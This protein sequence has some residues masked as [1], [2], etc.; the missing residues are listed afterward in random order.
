ML[1]SFS[2]TRPTTCP[3]F[4]MRN[5][6]RPLSKSACASQVISTPSAP[7]F[8]VTLNGAGGGVV[9]FVAPVFTYSAQ[10]LANS[11]MPLSEYGL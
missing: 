4:L 6:R 2:G 5:W 10:A 7:A 11:N 1:T 9:S 3:S 8:V